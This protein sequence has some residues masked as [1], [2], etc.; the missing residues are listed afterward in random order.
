MKVEG[1]YVCT[2]DPSPG[3]ASTSVESQLGHLSSTPHHR[4]SSLRRPS[5][6]LWEPEQKLSLV[7]FLP[8]ATHVGVL[9][10]LVI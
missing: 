9:W 2:P 8:H 7:L 3:R 4:H 5:E 10:A 6:G 1:A